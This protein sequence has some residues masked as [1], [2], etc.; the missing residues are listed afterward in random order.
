MHASPCHL[1]GPQ[2]PWSFLPG[3]LRCRHETLQERL[4]APGK[5]ILESLPS[6]ALRATRASLHPLVRVAWPCITPPHGMGRKHQAWSP[7]PCD[8]TGK[9]QCPGPARGIG[10][11][12]PEGFPSA[13]PARG[14]GG[15]LSRPPPRQTSLS[16]LLQAEPGA[17]R[18]PSPRTS[19]PT[20]LPV[21]QAGGRVGA[22]E[23]RAS[24]CFAAGAG[25]RRM[26]GTPGSLQELSWG[27][28]ARGATGQCWGPCISAGQVSVGL[29]AWCSLSTG[30]RWL[31]SLEGRE[32][33]PSGSVRRGLGAAWLSE[34]R[35]CFCHCKGSLPMPSLWVLVSTV[36]KPTPHEKYI[37][38]PV[39]SARRRARDVLSS[40]LLSPLRSRETGSAAWGR[41]RICALP[42]VYLQQT[43]TSA[44]APGHCSTAASG[45]A[46]HGAARGLGARGDTRSPRQLAQPC[47]WP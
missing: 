14:P 8:P 19:L 37:H 31:S 35:G 12:H 28:L 46:Q 21:T 16:S 27:R 5:S 25:A 7:E 24:R 15:Q 4:V 38:F 44:D 39:P 13:R 29:L 23:A 6:W 40:A 10:P 41:R 45:D 3:L 43:R 20:R 33:E 26:L 11:G 32:A 42:A 9:P 47:P 22:L 1:G 18:A 34:G 30:E 2:A 36:C 17:V